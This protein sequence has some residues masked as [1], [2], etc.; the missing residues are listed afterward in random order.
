MLVGGRLSDVLG[1]RAAF[2]TG[3][4]AFAAASL[5]AGAAPTAE[6]LL[7]GRCAQGAAAAVLA[8]ATLATITSVFVDDRTRTSA[9]AWWS[10]MSIAG[11]AAGNVLGGLLT[12][13]AGWRATLLINVPLGV[14]ALVLAVRAVPG[15]VSGPRPGIDGVPAAAVTAGLFALAYAVSAAGQREFADAGVAASLGA[16]L[17]GAFVVRDRRSAYPLVPREV[18]LS[19][20]IRW[21]NAGVFLAGAALVPMWMFLSLQMQEVLG[22][23]PSQA[24]L[25]FLPHTLIQLAVGLRVAPA[26]MRRVSAPVL[27]ATGAASTAAGFLVQSRLESGDTYLGAV[28]VPAVF[29][30]VG[31]GLFTL[32]LTKAAVACA[33]AGAVGLVSGIM[34]CTKQVGAGLGLSA[35]V[36][37]TGSIPGDVAAYRLAF[38]I[39]AALIGTVAIG[40]LAARRRSVFAGTD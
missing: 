35:L 39:M 29:I 4:A 16:I 10:A 24:G 36:A 14:V 19:R 5:L 13:H 25:G 33:P 17:V 38:H 21:G 9:M 3:S 27:I 31:A 6:V 26:L 18:F 32:P 30:A 40:A 2:V 20:P 15:R 23:T 11:G 1:V 22:Y 7:V 12:E 8:P 28:F 34:N 37:A